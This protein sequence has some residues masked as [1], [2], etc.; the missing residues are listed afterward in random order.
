M[1][2]RKRHSSKPDSKKPDLGEIRLMLWVL[3]EVIRCLASFWVTH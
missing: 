2:H 1:V 3:L